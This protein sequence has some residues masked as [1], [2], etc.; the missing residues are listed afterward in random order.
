MFM[1]LCIRRAIKKESWSC[2]LFKCPFNYN[3]KID[4]RCNLRNDPDKIVSICIHLAA[5]DKQIV[6]KDSY[7]FLN[8]LK[9]CD[10]ETEPILSYLK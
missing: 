4:A 7:M 1:I 5:V 2:L 3:P 8:N 9:N 10:W 6:S